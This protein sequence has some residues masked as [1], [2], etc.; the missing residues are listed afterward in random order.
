MMLLHS[1]SGG[2]IISQ[3]GSTGGSNDG[4]EESVGKA[5]PG[6][7]FGGNSPDN[8]G[9]PSATTVIQNVVSEDEHSSAAN[10]AT[11]VFSD[12]EG[13]VASDMGTVIINDLND[14]DVSTLLEKQEF[15]MK[16]KTLKINTVLKKATQKKETKNEGSE[17]FQLSS[18]LKIAVRE[19]VKD[20]MDEMTSKIQTNINELKGLLMTKESR[21]ESISDSSVHIRFEDEPREEKIQSKRSVEDN[22]DDQEDKIRRRSRDDHDK[23]TEGLKAYIKMNLDSTEESILQRI[24]EMMKHS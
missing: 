17:D 7:T 15:A 12:D 10:M 13:P 1:N 21:G 24:V 22:E 16:T 6:G 8:E 5:E 3:G 11:T 14:S 9:S 23:T 18:E 4:S 20:I 19:T 2:Q